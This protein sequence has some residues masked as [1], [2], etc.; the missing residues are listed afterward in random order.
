MDRARLLSRVYT[1][2]SAMHLVAKLYY[3]SRRN[4]NWVII[5]N[6]LAFVSVSLDFWFLLLNNKDP[7]KDTSY[8]M[9]FTKITS[10]FVCGMN[11]IT[12]C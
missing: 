2:L 9:I 1:T 10:P 6:Y 5:F 12:S 11:N 3:I 7:L 8:P 4:G